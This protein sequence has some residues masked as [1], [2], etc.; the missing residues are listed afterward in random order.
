MNVLNNV[1]EEFAGCI[2]PVGVLNQP[3]GHYATFFAGGSAMLNLIVKFDRE[4]HTDKEREEYLAGLQ[5]EVSNKARELLL[6]SVQPA[7][8]YVS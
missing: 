8:G 1:W 5:A 3:S 6:M 4:G 2:I 7:G